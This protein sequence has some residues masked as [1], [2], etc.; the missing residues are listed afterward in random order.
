[1]RATLATLTGE[2]LSAVIS[3]WTGQR[4]EMTVAF[5]GT[6]ML[7]AIA[8]GQRVLL[9]C[10]V[11]PQSGEVA[12]FLWQDQLAVHRVVAR[13]ANDSWLL[14]WGD[15]NLLPDDPVGD[16]TRIVG[17]IAAAERQGSMEP[18]MSRR[19]SLIRAGLVRFLAPPSAS[20]RAVARR[21]SILYRIRARLLWLRR[22]DSVPV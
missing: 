17:V 14:T 15:A 7:P 4:R 2:Q 10:G 9:R 1:M 22:D 16:P 13:A 19:R 8:P 21:V 11:W 5:G 12:V 6:S 20:F 3:F 18:V